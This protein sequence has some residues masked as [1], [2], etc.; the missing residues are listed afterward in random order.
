MA[1]FRLSTGQSHDSSQLHNSYRCVFLQAFAGF[2]IHR[3]GARPYQC[4]YAGCGSAFKH[5]R[6]LRTHEVVKHGRQKKFTRHSREE[7]INA[8]RECA[9]RGSVGSGPQGLGF[10]DADPE[11]L[12]SCDDN[13]TQESPSELPLT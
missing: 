13:L 11:S 10:L 12:S 2:K 4:T 7:W 9:A 6:S 1:D 8:F 3:A 5:I